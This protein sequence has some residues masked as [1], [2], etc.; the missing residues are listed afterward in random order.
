M[1]AVERETPDGVPAHAQGGTP[2]PLPAAQ[3]AD[4]LE[5]VE[6]EAV[7]ALVAGWAAGPM[8]AA[9]V[10]ARR[11]S[12]DLDW[13][14]LELARTGEVAGLFRR[15]DRL[16]AEAVPDV[17][18]GLAR[19]RIEGSVLDGLELAAIRRVLAAAREVHADLRRV[20]ETAP[21]AAALAHPLPDKRIERRLEQ[22]LDPDGS[23]LDTASP[24]L[25]AARREVH[26]ARSR[27]I[28]R[29]ESLLRGLDTGAAPADASVTVRGGRYVIPVRRDSRSRPDGI[30]HDE[31][32]SAGTLFVEPSAAI[33]LGNALREAEVAE[34]RETLRVLREL[35]G[36][37]RPELPA[38]HGIVEMCVA[39][40][41]LV[42]RARYAVAVEG[43]VP[44]VGPA[45]A[46]LRIVNGRHPLL[47]AGEAPVVPFDLE[48]D[49]S[50]RTLLISGPN[51]GG[52][53][54]L[55]KAVALAAALA[56]SGIVPPIG[57]GSRLPVFQRFYADIGDR[58]S[59]A[60]SLSTFSA[61]VAMLRR[62]LDEADAATL[63]LLDEVGS[64]TDPAE[65]AALAAATLASL[66][67][68]ATLTLATTHLGAL[69]NLASHTPGVVN[70]SLQ[71]D[72]A[73]LT[74]TYRFLKGVPGRSYG[75]AIARRLGVEPAILADAETRVPAAE[76]N[77]DAL[78]A[79]VEE[80]QRELRD[81]QATV[82][83]R[84]IE[85]ASLQA[86]LAVQQ[87]AQAARDAELR[88]REKDAE[89]AARQ[90]ARLF[91][92][93]ARARVE[94]ALGSARAAGDEA[95]AREA[96]R[97]VE[98]GIREQRERL[99]EAE[100]DAATA[101]RRGSG[102][103][104]APGARVRLANGGSGE[105]LDLRADGRAVV[106]MGAMKI[107][108]D[109]DSL[110]VLPAASRP[111]AAEAAPLAHAPSDA[112]SLELDLRGMTGDEAEQATIAA[113]DAAVLAEQ[114]FLRII[115]GMGT[116][117]VRERVRRVVSKDKRVARYGFA[118]RNQG[119]TGVTV[120]EFS[121]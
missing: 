52:K 63:V 75:L 34:E 47:L 64:G 73:T 83:S 108:V 61:H 79:T 84:T 88:R 107:V 57:P 99:E 104:V 7:L 118:P 11:P 101:G 113:V 56:Q 49:P 39:V 80:R 22:S 6:L 111:R 92:M 12:D 72:A 117:V 116:G 71:F 45:P 50:E 76:R 96:R 13:I 1:A 69:K 48:L 43:E 3:C 14:R 36:L 26:S 2:S 51:T 46:S 82:D 5:T 74:P 19:L 10:L 105:V 102:S 33:E 110:T 35:T 28:R 78:L 24:A 41:D 20:E 68:R 25:A 62:V 87:E 89:R 54:V 16:L 94:E 97:L 120:V 100:H 91:L 42:A 112:P 65:G 31:S 32:G 21:L 18:R 85:L 17:S 81:A 40:D 58:Q 93:E 115:H 66:T 15:G 121:A 37:L 53:T 119:G 44:E 114:P 95:A 38:L 109:A 27:L 86:R 103:A 8:G 4:A 70:A 9:R 67:G 59:I 98:E 30:V 77:L 55:L 23:V 29:L 106:A 60:A 90:Q